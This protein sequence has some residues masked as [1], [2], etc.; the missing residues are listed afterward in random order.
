MKGGR[1]FRF[2]AYKL[3]EYGLN[4]EKKNNRID[5]GIGAIGFM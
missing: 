2:R 3:Q 5:G 4:N 1:K